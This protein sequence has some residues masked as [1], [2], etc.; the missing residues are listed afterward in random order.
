MKKPL[1]LGGDIKALI[2][3]LMMVI[4]MMMMMTMMI[5]MK[6]VLGIYLSIYASHTMI[7][8]TFEN[9][10]TRQIG[11]HLAPFTAGKVNNPTNYTAPSGL[12]LG[13]QA[14]AFLEQ[15]NLSRTTVFF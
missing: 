6:K 9:R 3:M 15:G 1:L 11:V 2:I 13:K 14:P 10:Q 8:R 7:R 5:E 12:I 4:I